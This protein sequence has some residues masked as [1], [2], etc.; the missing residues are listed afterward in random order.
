MCINIHKSTQQNYKIENKIFILNCYFG[1]DLRKKVMS[2][3][4][5]FLILFCN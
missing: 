4:F 1:L 3:D 5:L 2:L